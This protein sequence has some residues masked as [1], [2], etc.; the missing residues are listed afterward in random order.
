VSTL[1]PSHYVAH[2]SLVTFWFVKL[3]ALMALPSLEVVSLTQPGYV[4][5]PAIETLATGALLGNT[6]TW[7]NVE[8]GNEVLIFEV[9]EEIKLGTA[10]GGRLLSGTMLL[11]VVTLTKLVDKLE[12]NEVVVLLGVG[13]VGEVE[14]AI[15][16]DVAAMLV[17]VG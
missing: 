11:A 9:V 8:D 16:V 1:F 3:E 15:M 6:R 4:N 7:E 17:T 2:T 14:V 10:V 5:Q 12:A 13:I